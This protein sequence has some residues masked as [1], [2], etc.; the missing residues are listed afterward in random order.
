MESS[1]GDSRVS[2]FRRFFVSLQSLGLL[3]KQALL[4]LK[5]PNSIPVNRL[6]PIASH[7]IAQFSVEKLFHTRTR[8]TGMIFNDFG[9]MF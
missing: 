7:L 1:C 3:F 9:Y 8:F 6:L 5:N 4:E 2:S